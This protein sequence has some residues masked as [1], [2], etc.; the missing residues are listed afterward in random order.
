[1]N[2]PTTTPQKWRDLS[3][4]DKAAIVTACISFFLGFVLLYAGLFI[5]PV[6]EI[7]GSVLTGFGT[8][9][10]YTAGIFGVS[11]YFKH[12]NNE[13]FNN[14]M[15]SLEDVIEKKLQQHNANN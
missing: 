6:G 2:N 1:M 13:L 5:S 15:D 8:A 14:L 11:M 4:K 9:L 3:V 7:D 10:L 12:G